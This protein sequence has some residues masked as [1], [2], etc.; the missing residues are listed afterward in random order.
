MQLN[1]CLER[2]STKHSL[3]LSVSPCESSFGLQPTLVKC[4]WLALTETDGVTHKGSDPPSGTAK[5]KGRVKRY[6]NG[7]NPPFFP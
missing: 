4:F 7:A 3:S 1:G 5:A 6:P 2:F